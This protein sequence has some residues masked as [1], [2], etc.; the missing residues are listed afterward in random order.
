MV[1]LQKSGNPTKPKI[2]LSLQVKIISN[3]YNKAKGSSYQWTR[4]FKKGHNC[5]AVQQF[6]PDAQM[7]FKA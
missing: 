5:L 6:F 3:Y 4:I 7:R 1:G 2:L